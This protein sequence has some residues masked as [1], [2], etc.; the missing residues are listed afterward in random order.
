MS[1][2]KIPKEKD[3][4]LQLTTNLLDK[5]I[6]VCG[7]LVW[8]KEIDYNLQEYRVKFRID[9]NERMELIRILNEV[10]IKMRKNALFDEG[11]FISGTY[12]QYFNR[13]N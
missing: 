5:E 8:A 12:A 2:I 13:E 1:N 11:S 9:E 10:Q 6:K 4:A 7:H 3:I